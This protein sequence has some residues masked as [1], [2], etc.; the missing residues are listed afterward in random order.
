[1][2]RNAPAGHT[3][4]RAGLPTSREAYENWH[5]R[6]DVDTA[7]DT[8]WHRQVR[9]RV[10]EAPLPLRGRV[11]EIGAG[12]GGFASWLATRQ[13]VTR[14]VAADFSGVGVRMGRAHAARQG[15]TSLDWTVA[16]IQSIP[17]ASGAFDAVFSC[18]T[19]EHIPSPAQGL[20]E[21]WRILRPGGRLFLTCPN[22]LGLMGAYRA[23]LRLRGRPFTEDGQPIN[24]F[25]LLPVT[26]AMVRAAGFQIDA[27][28]S[29]GHYLPWP[30]APPRDLGEV[31]PSWLARWFGLHSCVVATR[32]T[33]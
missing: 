32:P 12:R 14:V 31:G 6:L 10:E 1:M 24:R 28:G 27:F 26:L 9:A 13:G 23:Y 29:T 33:P 11:L 20:K 4:P 17:F 16:D 18:E 22:Y 15:L 2:Q 25:L 30:G 7:A 5:A 3:S 21:L 8:P 19:I